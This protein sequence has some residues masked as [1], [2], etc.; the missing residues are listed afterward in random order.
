MNKLKTAGQT[1]Q[2]RGRK[3]TKQERPRHQKATRNSKLLLRVERKNKAVWQYTSTLLAVVVS[4]IT[5]LRFLP[6][7]VLT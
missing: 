2:K 7:G 1:K 4:Q 5:L 3:K 6:N